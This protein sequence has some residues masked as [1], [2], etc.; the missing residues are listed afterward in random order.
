[1]IV[2]ITIKFDQWGEEL[3]PKIIKLFENIKL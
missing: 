1:M 2:T 3:F